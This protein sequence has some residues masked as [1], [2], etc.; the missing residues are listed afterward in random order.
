MIRKAW[1]TGGARTGRVW[2]QAASEIPQVT[3]CSVLLHII[4]VDSERS[5]QEV[6]QSSELR[7]ERYGG[8]SFIKAAGECGSLMGF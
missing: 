6:M 7:L 8:R 1:L 5:F 4:Q 2:I 3:V